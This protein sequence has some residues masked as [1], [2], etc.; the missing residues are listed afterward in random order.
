[1]PVTGNP[2]KIIDQGILGACDP[3]EKCGFADIGTA[4]DGNN[5][6]HDKF[7]WYIKFILKTNEIIPIENIYG[8]S[9]QIAIIFQVRHKI[10]KRDAP[11]FTESKIGDNSRV[12]C[13]EDVGLDYLSDNSNSRSA[14]S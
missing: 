9:S 13:E 7:Y 5:G 1:M 10:N 12:V 8:L 14:L 11:C 6:F 4:D 3:I 2:R